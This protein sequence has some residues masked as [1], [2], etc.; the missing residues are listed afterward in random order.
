MRE[1]S[2]ARGAGAGAGPRSAGPAARSSDPRPPAPRLGHVPKALSGPAAWSRRRGENGQRGGRH[3][4]LPGMTPRGSA[5]SSSRSC[6]TPRPRGTGFRCVCCLVA[7]AVTMASATGRRLQ[8]EPP[9]AGARKP[10]VGPEAS[11]T[12]HA[13][14]APCPGGGPCSLEANAHPPVVQASTPG[15]FQ[16]E[17]HNS[18]LWSA[19]PCA[20]GSGASEMPRQVPAVRRAQPGVPAA[21]P[22]C[23]CRAAHHPPSGL[24]PEASKSDSPGPPRSGRLK[25][26]KGSDLAH[27]LGGTTPT[28]IP[29]ATSA[30]SAT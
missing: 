24:H 21:P 14:Q 13:P 28:P 1:D 8:P 19:L 9:Q 25:P 27:F 30:P 16:R 29:E 7:V 22:S 4:L 26:R 20:G 23:L 10:H 2:E 12:G 3:R 18:V 6:E 11:Q 5:G 17:P 15:A